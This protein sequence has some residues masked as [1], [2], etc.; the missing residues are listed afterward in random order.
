MKN[1]E[2]I[3]S[4]SQGEKIKSGLIWLNQS[5]EFWVGLTPEEQTGAERVIRILLDMVANEVILA[6]RV[7]GDPGWEDVTK[8]IGT[9]KTMMNSGV[10]QE[11]PYHLTQALHHTTSIGQRSMSQLKENGLL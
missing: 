5:L 3:L 6:R 1:S 9:A 2:A 4:L 8:H 11:A 10:L 7:T